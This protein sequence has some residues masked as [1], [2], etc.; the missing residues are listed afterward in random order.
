MTHA[1]IRMELSK[2][3]LDVNLDQCD[4]DI[5]W[6]KSVPRIP[7]SVEGPF[8]CDICCASFSQ[9]RYLQNHQFTHGEK[10]FVCEICLKAF[11]RKDY[12]VS[13]IALHNEE[14]PFVCEVCQKAFKR[15]DYLFSH[16]TIHIEEKPFVC[17]ICQKTFKRKQ[18]LVK[19]TVIHTEEKPFVCKICQK[20]FKRKQEVVMHCKRIYTRPTTKKI[21]PTQ[22]TFEENVPAPNAF[23]KLQGYCRSFFGN[24]DN[25]PMPVCHVAKF[26]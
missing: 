22:E 14:N 9:K 7:R 1:F 8:V 6:L 3:N 17:E 11:K 12:L 4:T 19:H 26:D 2:T 20:A 24:T 18:D 21:I 15:K 23:E 16:K 13:H 10:T 5:P 25:K